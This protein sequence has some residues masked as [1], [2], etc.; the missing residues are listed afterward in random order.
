M[1]NEFSFKHLSEMR[2][3]INGDILLLEMQVFKA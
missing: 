3:K 2:E 1:R